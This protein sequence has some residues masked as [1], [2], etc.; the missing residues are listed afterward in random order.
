MTRASVSISSFTLSAANDVL[1]Q[2]LSARKNSSQLRRRCFRSAFRVPIRAAVVQ[3]VS[4][5]VIT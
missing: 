3:R 5:E 2:A 1:Q 4:Y